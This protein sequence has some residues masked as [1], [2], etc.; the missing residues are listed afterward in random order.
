[1]MNI[2][3]QQQFQQFG[4]SQPGVLLLSKLDVSA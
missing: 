1:M 4:F 2:Q 3:F